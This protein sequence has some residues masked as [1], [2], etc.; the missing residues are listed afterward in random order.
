M[1]AALTMTDSHQTSTRRARRWHGG[2]RNGFAP[3]L[4]QPRVGGAWRQGDPVGSRRFA[5]VGDVAL[6]RG[7]TIG[8][9]TV[10]YETWG[11][12]N[13]TR[14]NVVLIEHALTGDSHVDGEAGDGHASPGWRP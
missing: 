8:D 14:D 5:Q 7:G 1:A 3:P 2:V 6:E 10:A 12:L 13:A 4:A 9:V 11:T